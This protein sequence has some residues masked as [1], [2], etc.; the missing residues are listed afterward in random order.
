M[1]KTIDTSV[2]APEM[3]DAFFGAL[4]ST[5]GL[6]AALE[7]APEVECEPFCYTHKNA[8]KMFGVSGSAM[9]YCDNSDWF[10][11]PL[12]LHPPSVSSDVAAQIRAL[13]YAYAG[14]SFTDEV[15]YNRAID[16]VIK[17]I[18]GAK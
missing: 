16:D 2:V 12:Y 4:D 17:I 3:L 10:S 15:A 14:R 7:A 1:K 6:K 8:E 5:E 9:A 11:V 13:K 18:E